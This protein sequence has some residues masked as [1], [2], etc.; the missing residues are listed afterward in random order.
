MRVQH[1]A[2]LGSLAFLLLTIPAMASLRDI[3]TDKLPSDESVRKAY[4]A[5][6]SVEE[7][8]DAWSTDWRYPTPK[9]VV[10][11][12]LNESLES[13]QKAAAS[14]PNNSELFLLTG[15]VAHY[16]YNVDVKD[17]YDLAVRSL[18]KAHKLAPDDYRPEWFLGDHQCQAGQIKEGMEAL[19]A[20]EARLPWDHLPA[21]F[22]DD[23]VY[24]ANLANMPAHVLRA[25][26]HLNKLHAPPSET[27][28]FLLDVARKRFPAP[29]LNATYSDREAWEAGTENSHLVFKSSLCGLSFSPLAEWKIEKLGVQ[30]GLCFVQLQTG[31]HESKVGNVFPNLLIIARPAK[32]GETVNDFMK[33]FMKYPSP[34]SF[35]VSRCPSDPCLAY[36]AVMP[37]AY[38]NAGN[39]HVEMTAFERTEPPFP[40]LLFEEPAG[41]TPTKDGKV[42]YFHPSEH[43]HRLPGTLYYLVM[44][45]TADSV[46]DDAKRDYDT[47][48]KDLQAE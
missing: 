26:D 41:P 28:T 39:G 5:A 47:L 35:A 46:L 29:D 16:A 43:L 36:E 13:L 17:A 2:V 21:T 24:C 8:S 19:L 12:R 4:A 42:A 30:K 22:W 9:A 15:I 31:P 45:D 37:K 34:S 3:H 10:A 23:Y 32:Q 40:G 44:L 20:V 7:F 6:A 14:A 1:A 11:A 25:G 38:G 18:Q 27:R 33:A 48:L